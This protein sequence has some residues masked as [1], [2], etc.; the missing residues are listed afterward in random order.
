[1]MRRMR[2]WPPWSL[3]APAKSPRACP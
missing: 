3:H 1:L 2:R